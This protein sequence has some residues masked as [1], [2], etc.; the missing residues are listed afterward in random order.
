MSVR[1]KGNRLV[2]VKNSFTHEVKR[3]KRVEAIE[4]VN[5]GNW[6]FTGR[7]KFRGN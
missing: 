4:L 7:K 5:S 1:D 2:T 3:I 6:E